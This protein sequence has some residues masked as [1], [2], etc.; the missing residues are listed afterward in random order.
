[1]QT[2]NGRSH[3]RTLLLKRQ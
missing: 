2:V 1:M 3:P